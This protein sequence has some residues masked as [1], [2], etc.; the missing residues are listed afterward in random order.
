MAKNLLMLCNVFSQL[1]HL[2]GAFFIFLLFS[3]QLSLQLLHFDL[4][5][6]QKNVQRSEALYCIYY[7]PEYFSFKAI[8]QKSCNSG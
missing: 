6:Y 5:E 1:L 3:K 2:K 8:S 7:L 4:R